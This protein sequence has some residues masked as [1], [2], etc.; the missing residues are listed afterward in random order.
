M[1]VTIAPAP[2]GEAQVAIAQTLDRAWHD[3]TGNEAL[4]EAVWLDLGRYMSLEG[5][6]S[7]SEAGSEHHHHDRNQPQPQ[8]AMGAPSGFQMLPPQPQGGAPND[9]DARE[10]FTSRRIYGLESLAGS[11]LDALAI[12][13][14][15]LRAGR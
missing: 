15:M 14:Q 10:H 9:R 12:D 7:L 4:N 8:P 11:G 13:Q 1:G 2:A 6:I 3:W 5:A